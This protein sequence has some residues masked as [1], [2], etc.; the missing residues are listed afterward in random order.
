VWGRATSARPASYFLPCPAPWPANKTSSL[1]PRPNAGAA[2]LP[3]ASA[4]TLHRRRHPQRGRTGLPA[5]LQHAADFLLQSAPVGAVRTK[6]SVVRRNASSPHP[7]RSQAAWSSTPTIWL[8]SPVRTHLFLKTIRGSFSV[9]SRARPGRLR[10]LPCPPS[11]LLPRFR[12]RSRTPP[13]TAA[14]IAAS[15]QSLDLARGGLTILIETPPEPRVFPWRQ[16]PSKSPRS[17]IASRGVVPIAA[18]IDTCHTHVAGLRH[19]YRRRYLPDPCQLLDATV[20]LEQCEK[21]IHCNDAKAA[22]GI[23]ARPPSTHRQGKPSASNLSA[24]CSTIFAWSTP[25]SS[26]RLPLTSP[27]TIAK[28]SILLRS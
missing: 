13:N 22:R 10:R 24:S 17:L 27:A 1:I 4:S 20:G 9:V 5:W 7:V 25:P 16:F 6:P 26:P 2:S 12:S 15:T 23:E 3:A 21:V 8:I 18:C 14:A 11:W 28:M 19:R